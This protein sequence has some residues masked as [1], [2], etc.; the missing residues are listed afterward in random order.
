MAK[1][2]WINGAIEP[3]ET[4]EY[5]VIVELLNDIGPLKKGD[6]I[7]DG[8]VYTSTGWGEYY[9]IYKVLSWARILYPDIPADLQG[10]VKW[11]FGKDVRDDG[12]HIEP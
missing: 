8:D 11:Y 6:V 4:G 7:M 5:F 12:A 2:N 9:G 1:V 10:R 3:P